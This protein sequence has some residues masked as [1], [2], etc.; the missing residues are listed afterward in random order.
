MLKALTHGVPLLC[1]PLRGDQ[2]DIAAR[3]VHASAG[4]RLSP[5]ASAFEIRAALQQVLSD[6]KFR[7]AARRVA[8]ILETENGLQ[9]A[10]SE[11]ESVA[12]GL[13]ARQY[14]KGV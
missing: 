11:L 3:V 12:A 6:P 7:K 9:T 14:Q 13:G 1:I 4:L 10:V 2:P 5:T 8:S